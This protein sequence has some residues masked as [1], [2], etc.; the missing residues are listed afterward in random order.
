MVHIVGNRS[1]LSVSFLEAVA[2]DV[3][4]RVVAYGFFLAL[5]RIKSIAREWL[6]MEDDGAF[7]E[8]KESFVDCLCN[9]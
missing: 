3:K 1:W 7:E 6:P 8:T 4:I 5:W 9:V 2:A